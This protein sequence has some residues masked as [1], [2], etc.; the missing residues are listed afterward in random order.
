MPAARFEGFPGMVPAPD[1]DEE[2]SLRGPSHGSGGGRSVR[3]QAASTLIVPS[4]SS[5]NDSSV[6][7]SSA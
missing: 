1:R 4:A 3:H 6:A 7:F 2:S 5:L